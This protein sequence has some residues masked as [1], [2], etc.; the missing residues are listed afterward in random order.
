MDYSGWEL[1]YFDRS[2]NFR[3]YEFELISKYI[4]GKILEVGPGSGI[5]LKYYADSEK[6]IVLLE[7]NKK[8]FKN[9]HDKF[10]NEA[11]IKLINSDIN[12]IDTKFDTILYLDVLEHIEYDEQEIL[13]SYS[14]L[15]N[16]GYLVFVVPAFQFL[17]TNYDI[18]VG[19]YR[20]YNKSFFK[21][22]SKNNNINCVELKY[23]DCF[24][25]FFILAAKLF[26]SN[27]K[28]T[29]NLGTFIWN[30]L[31][32]V[33]KFFDKIIFNSFGKSAICVLKKK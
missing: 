3:N 2:T 7:T 15:N 27:E 4:K 13:K 6:D 25:F 30:M 17:F 20:R 24:G 21:K 8:I 11:N 10:V 29:I 31:I 19:H 33:S 1:E 12:T 28:K 23:F 22:F 32:P 9:L 5:N 16:G 18:S 26:R 14:L